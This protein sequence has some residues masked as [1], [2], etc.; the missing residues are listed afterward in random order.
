MKDRESMSSCVSSSDITLVTKCKSG[1]NK[2]WL[3]IWKKIV[4]QQGIEPR[5]LAI[6]VSVK[7]TEDTWS[8]EFFMFSQ[9][10]K[11]ANIV[12]FVLAVPFIIKKTYKVSNLEM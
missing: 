2:W 12:N 3:V 9:Q 8:V 7:I 5:I 1:L 4:P 10:Y 11:N 6:R